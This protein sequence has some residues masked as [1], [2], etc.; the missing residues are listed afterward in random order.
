MASI[1][2]TARAEWTPQD[3]RAEILHRFRRSHQPIKDARHE[4]QVSKATVAKWLN[5]T[6]N[7]RPRYI[8]VFIQWR[9]QR[10]AWETRW[11]E[12]R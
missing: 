1:T 2:N 12:R 10:R 6:R 8:R 5:G 3:I 11:G 9:G 7:P 4:L